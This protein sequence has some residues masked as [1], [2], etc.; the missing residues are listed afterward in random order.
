LDLLTTR[1][2]HSELQVITE[3]PLISTSRNSPQKL[4]SF[5]QPAVSSQAVPWQQLLTVEILQLLLLL[6]FD[7]VL[8]DLSGLKQSPVRVVHR[9]C[10]RSSL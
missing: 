7:V 1:K 4:L 10:I 9:S 6:S 2:H 3:Q 8:R 5:L